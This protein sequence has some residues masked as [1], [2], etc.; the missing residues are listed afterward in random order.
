[1]LTSRTSLKSGRLRHGASDEKGKAGRVKL[2]IWDCD[3]TL[4]DS[5]NAIVEAM[6]YAF[7]SI[8]APPPDRKAV[9]TVVGLSL[10]EAFVQLHPDG[11][12]VTR[13]A[14]AARYKNAFV[15]LRHDPAHHEPLY[16]GIAEIIEMLSARD[17][18]M[19]AIATGKSRRGVDRLLAREGWQTAFSSIQ[20]ADGHPSKPHPSMIQQAMLETGTEPHATVMI[21]DTTYDIEMARA[22]RVGALGVDWGYHDVAALERAGAHKIAVAPSE[23]EAYASEIIADLAASRSHE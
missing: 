10:P 15:E 6:D 17:D 13:E 20:T 3:G 22:A 2:I 7:S 12:V 14:L 5:Q 21:G 4:I 8:G 23:L 18:V 16:T 11:D 1:M 9:M 19:M